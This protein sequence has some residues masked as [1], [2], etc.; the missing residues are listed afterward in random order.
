MMKQSLNGIW[1]IRWTDG[2]RGGSPHFAKEPGQPLDAD[3]LGHPK[4]ISNL[5]DP[6]KWIDASVPG[7]VH[8][9]LLRAGLIDD[10]YI[11]TNVLKCR[12]VEEFVWYYR[13]VFDAPQA[14]CSANA[15]IR[16]MGLD[17]GAVIY[18]NGREIAR[19]ANAFRPLLVDVT[20]KLSDKGNVLVVA[21][22]S[23][24]YSISE[25]KVSHLYSATMGVDNLLHKRMWLR[26]PQSST[27]WDWSPR[28]LNVGVFGNVELLWGDITI[29]KQTQVRSTT[30]PDLKSAELEIRFF[31]SVPLPADSN[32][33]A[34]VSLNGIEFPAEV[35]TD[36]DHVSATISV[37]SPKLWFPAGYGEHYLY[38]LIYSLEC[39]GNTIDTDERRIGF[40]HVHVDQ[41]P[42]PEGGNY[43][44]LNVNGV[45][46]FAKGA[47]L[48]PADMIIA[49][50]DDDRYDKL[51]DLALEANFNMLR[52]WGG[53]VYEDDRFYRFCDEKGLLVWQEFISACATLPY[54]DQDFRDEVHIEARYQMR[55]LSGYPSLIVWCGNNEVDVQGIQRFKG[56]PDLPE[57]S[58]LYYEALPEIL[59]DED[60]EKYYQPS[61]PYSFDGSYADNELVGDQHP[62]AVGFDNKD[63]R[64]YRNMKCRFPNEGGVLGSTS[65]DN[66]EDCL[67]PGQRYLHSFSWDIHDN[68]LEGWKPGTSSDANVLFWLDSDVRKLAL[69]E[70]VYALGA[71]QADGLTTYIDHFRS[72]KFDTSAAI[73]WMYN[74]CWPATISWTIVDHK[75]RRTPSFYPVKRAFE[76]VRVLLTQTSEGF[77]ILVNNDSLTDVYLTLITGFFSCDGAKTPE[78]ESVVNIPANSCAKYDNLPQDLCEK[79][80]IPYALLR[81]ADGKILSQNRFI[82]A[83]FYELPLVKEPVIRR[84]TGDGWVAFTSDVFVPYACVGLRGDD[85]DTDNFF[86]LL[87]GIPYRIETAEKETDIVYTLNGI[88]GRK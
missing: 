42:H 35:K 81:D 28:L 10:P 16:F 9:D 34:K 71:V 29:V 22:E 51:T 30:S 20:G 23:G 78:R 80:M 67:E 3:L 60:P 24:L 14:A 63:H 56:Y 47:N 76:H 36:D 69:E 26:K 62:W 61:S 46:V 18:L 6:V 66:I 13:K 83:R 12:W 38:D 40:R 77:D 53:G 37:D 73:F 85:R 82:S 1:K 8:L 5:Y 31:L 44:I 88:I 70:A 4:D 72:R 54:T 19:H 15:V 7:E 68:M 64:L 17:Y 41:S 43:F 84:E 33:S 48:V 50:I 79:N 55:R 57:D 32:V 59:K 25:K 58:R 21:L 49:A 75:L 2:Q 87:P 86:D 39:N 65:L 74:D 27:A 52:V 11:G 45:P